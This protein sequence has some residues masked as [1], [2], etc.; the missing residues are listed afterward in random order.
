[1]RGWLAACAVL[2]FSGLS[3]SANAQEA[4]PPPLDRARVAAFIDGAVTGLMRSERVAGVTVAVIDRQGPVYLQGYGAAGEERRV[5]ADTLFRV[6]SISKTPTWIAL[7]QLVQE[8]KLTLDDPINDHLPEALRIPDGGYAE[9]IRIRHLLTHSA[10]FEDSALG[11]LFVRDPAQLLS[12]E[13]YLQRYRV[14]RV[15]P[16]GSLAVYSNYGADLAGAIVAHESGMDFPTYAEARIFRPLGMTSTTYR[17]PYSA[18]IAAAQRLPAPMAL[19]LAGR[20]TEG[21]RYLAGQYEAQPFEYGTHVAAAGSMSSSANDMAVYMAALLDPAQMAAAG[22]LKAETAAALTEPLHANFEGWGEWRH[23]FMTIALGGGRWAYGHS[24]DTLFQHSAML[25]SPALGF[26]LFVSTNTETGPLLEFPMIDA[27]VREF[28]PAPDEPARVAQVTQAESA[29][30]AGT[31]RSLRRPYHRTERALFNMIGAMPV[32]ALENGDLLIG[33]GPMAERVE[34]LGDGVYGARDGADRIAFREVDGRMRLYESFGAAPS[35]RIGFFE[36][37]NWLGLIGGLGLIL[38]L[39][40]VI[41]GAR[42]LVAGKASAA[43]LVFD[44]LCA[45]WLVAFGLFAAAV[46]PWTDQAA[47]VFGY[48]GPFFPVAAWAMAFAAAATAAALLAALTVWRP[49]DWSWLRWARAGAA[50]A[51]FGA[52]SVTLWQFGFLGYSGF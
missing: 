51:V 12:I 36:T 23:G 50:V 22:V 9:P 1:M 52:L 47:A 2:I 27:F 37:P 21:Y 17:E 8:G 40:G 19:E 10:G 34:P 3:F 32:V 38:S 5:D 44:G 26:G 16:A 29:R 30:F 14:R 28:Y 35:E 46:L 24:G 31:Y 39:W 6:G 25:V 4:A 20:V 41:A 7:M 43:T 49:R 33:A 42:R 18:E 45:I 13:D 11:H 15:R 48:P